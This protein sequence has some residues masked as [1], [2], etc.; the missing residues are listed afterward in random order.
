MHPNKAARKRII[1]CL[2]AADIQ[3]DVDGVARSATIVEHPPQGGWIS[4]S[5]LP[6]IYCFARSERITTDSLTADKRQLL[7]DVVLQASGDRDE[8]IDQ[9]DDMQL[10]V[11]VALMSDDSMGGLFYSFRVVGS[12]VY[13]NQ[14]EVVFAA[15]RVSFEAELIAPRV[16][17]DIL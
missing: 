5:L 1:A 3:I 6:G 8:V 10:A 15:R 4:E 2:R 12:E 9:V 16:N 7:I 17:P 11:E 13:T 14:G